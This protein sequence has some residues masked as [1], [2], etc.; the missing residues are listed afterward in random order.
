MKLQ[1]IFDKGARHLMHMDGPSVDT[2]NDACVYRGEDADGCY[3]GKMCAVGVFIKD[4]FYDVS[5]EGRVM[6]PLDAHGAS[7]EGA[8][9]NAVAKSIGQEKLT[10]DQADLFADL[11]FAHDAKSGSAFDEWMDSVIKTLDQIA[12]RHDFQFDPAHI[13]P[14]YKGDA[15]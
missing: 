13:N 11:Q 14:H 3:D 1:D 12:R 8:L 2:F 5:L 15:L 4:E 6:R 9:H 7:T 10:Q